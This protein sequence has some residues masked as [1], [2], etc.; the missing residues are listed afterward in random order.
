MRIENSALK[1]KIFV[2]LSLDLMLKT[3]LKVHF[4]SKSNGE[5][6]NVKM[7]VVNVAKILFV[8]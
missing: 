7:V 8:K 1:I 2:I 4:K 3:I 6:W 5:V